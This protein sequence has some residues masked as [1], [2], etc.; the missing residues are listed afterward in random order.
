M[1]ESKLSW[2]TNRTS[3][4][5]GGV[6]AF[7]VLV[8]LLRGIVGLQPYSAT[9]LL[10]SFGAFLVGRLFKTETGQG[11]G[12][13][14]SSFLGNL[15]VA[16]FGFIISIWFLG[17]IASL[18]NDTFPTALSSRVPGFAIG[19]IASGLVAY[20]SQDSAPGT[21]EESRQSQHS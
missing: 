8:W 20:G 12:R 2:F 13:A 10:V 15:A 14:I 7:L 3:R 17:W 5:L 6:S 9:M 16:F 11:L 4:V 1:R 18:Q 21:K 19:L